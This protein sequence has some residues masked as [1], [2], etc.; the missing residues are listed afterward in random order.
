MT[1]QFT[2][3]LQKKKK[4]KKVTNFKIVVSTAVNQHEVSCSSGQWV[5]RIQLNLSHNHFT[6]YTPANNP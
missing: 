5:H 1:T 4:K 2:P 6:N 3:K